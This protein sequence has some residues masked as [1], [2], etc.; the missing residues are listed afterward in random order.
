VEQVGSIWMVLGLV[1]G[2]ELRTKPKREE[3]EE[4]CELITRNDDR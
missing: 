3:S 4:I 2:I 1:F